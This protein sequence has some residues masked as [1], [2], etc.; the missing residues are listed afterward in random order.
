MDMSAACT[1]PRHDTGTTA[2][3]QHPRWA[4]YRSYVSAMSRQMV[5]GASFA[6]WLSSTEE[7]ENGKRVVFDV[8]P[9][10]RMAAGWY[11]NVFAPG[12]RDPETFGPFATKAEAEAG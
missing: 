9:G 4:D 12:K 11:V 8:L 6:S 5:S 2:E 10:A 1:A 3:R 7:F